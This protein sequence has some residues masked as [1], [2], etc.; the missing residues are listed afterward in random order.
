MKHIRSHLY[1]NIQFSVE[2]YPF[3]SFLFHQ[4]LPYPVSFT[5]LFDPALLH[6][7]SRLI[8]HFEPEY[9]ET[10]AV[11][12]NHNRSASIGRSQSPSVQIFCQHFLCFI[13]SRAC[14]LDDGRFVWPAQLRANDFVRRGWSCG[15]CGIETISSFRRRRCGRM[16]VGRHVGLSGGDGGS[17][18]E[19]RPV[20]LFLYEDQV[21]RRR[22]CLT[23][24]QLLAIFRIASNQRLVWVCSARWMS[25]RVLF[26]RT[27]QLNNSV[28]L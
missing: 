17:E 12:R 26:S 5:C 9:L 13:E 14:F 10:H 22:R 16:G 2:L 1:P 24:E 27:A 3:S 6:K 19:R 25:V 23:H 28:V 11:I 18:L 21:C 4:L 7:H 15:G 8:P 20:H